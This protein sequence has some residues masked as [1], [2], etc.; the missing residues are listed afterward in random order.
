MRTYRIH[1]STYAHVCLDRHLQCHAKLQ[2]ASSNQPFAKGRGT[3]VLQNMLDVPHFELHFS[4]FPSYHGRLLVCPRSQNSISNWGTSSM[5]CNTS[6]LLYLFQKLLIATSTGLGPACQMDVQLQ[7]P[8][9][10][11]SAHQQGSPDICHVLNARRRED[12]H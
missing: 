4:S 5:F 2:T 7:Y 3:M 1:A 6:R 9:S 8:N 11:L 12:C 10:G